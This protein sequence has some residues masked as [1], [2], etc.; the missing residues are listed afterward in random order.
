MWIGL[1][2]AALAVVLCCGGGAAALVGLAVAGTQAI[3]EQARAVVGSYYQA[4]R[5]EHYG[6]AYELLCDTSK[7]RESPQEFQRRVS[8]EPHIASYQV[9][10]AT[11]ANE[12]TVPV[13][14]SYTGGSQA[15]QKVSLA[16]NGRTGTL[17]VC[18]V[19]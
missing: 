19:S 15:T 11:V 16:Q 5:D 17:E 13:Q 6:R 3:N 8:A 10:A 12:V 18:G 1:G 7:R 14:V 2:V 9:G 4:V